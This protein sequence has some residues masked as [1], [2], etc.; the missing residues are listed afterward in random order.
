[1][2]DKYLDF[3]TVLKKTIEHE[4]DGDT[5]W[6]WCARYNQQRIDNGVLGKKRTSRGHTNDS[7]INIG[8]NTENSFGD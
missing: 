3:V 4:S 1:M 5:N 8:E 2:K 6:S 7:I